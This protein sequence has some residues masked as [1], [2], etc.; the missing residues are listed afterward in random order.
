VRCERA[1]PAA[2]TWRRYVGRSGTVVSLNTGDNE[3][4][5]QLGDGHQLVWFT[6]D[7][8]VRL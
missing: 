2:G 3:V 7:E 1:R 4:G 8:L 5:V 6:P